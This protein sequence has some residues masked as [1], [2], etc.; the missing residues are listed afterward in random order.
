MRVKIMP[1]KTKVG[2]LYNTL[3]RRYNYPHE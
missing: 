3:K 1:G 2:V